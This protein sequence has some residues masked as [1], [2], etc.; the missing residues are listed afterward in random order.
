MI[1]SL[2]ISGFKLFDEIHLSNFGRLNL[3][4]GENNSGK[5]CLLEAVGMYAGRTPTADIIQA[6]SGRSKE[7]LRPWDAEGTNEAE[8]PLLH[9][10]FDL[11]HR[12]NGRT[13]NHILIEE[14]GHPY[15][16]RIDYRFHHLIADEGF[17]R[18]VPA[19]AGDVVEH[20]T[21]MALRVFRG[22]E[23][24]GLLTRRM[25]P[26]RSRPLDDK[27]RVHDTFAVA[28]L[29][30]NGF[31][32]EKAAAMWDVLVQGPGQDLVL[33]WLRLIEPKIQDL[34][35]VSGRLNSRIAL[36]K[37]EH[38]GRI[39]LR[40][41]GD[42][43]TRIFHTGLAM[44]SAS[45]GVLLI[46]EFE[47]GLHWKTQEMIWMAIGEAA[48]QF[49]VQIF[50]TT[51]SRDCIESFANVTREL[52]LEDSTM[53]RLERFDERILATQLPMINVNAALRQHSEVR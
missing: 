9:P 22:D 24:V 49:G 8:S 38:E 34:V 30:A 35:Y 42:G 51:H 5:S 36:L 13:A 48:Q 1:H 44:A 3:F 21:E 10:V 17:R 28:H 41:L 25:L 33:R 14:I 31:S 4:L 23:Q 18:Y 16:L 19:Q 37:M 32:E 47:N 7:L 12:E 53:Y 50:A 2:H 29:P 20:P 40:S 26:L 15:P 39:P 46:D 45:H 6:A 27:L 11:F 52:G 43:L